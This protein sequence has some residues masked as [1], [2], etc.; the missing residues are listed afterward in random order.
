MY[1]LLHVLFF[2]VSSSTQKQM[3]SKVRVNELE[4]YIR[5]ECLEISGIPVDQH[6]DTNSIVIK[7]GSLMGVI[8]EKSDISVSHRLPSKSQSY[9]N[10]VRQGRSSL[11]KIIAKFVRRD[12]RDQFYSGRKRLKNKTTSDLGMTGFAGSNRIYISESLSP[13]NKRLFQECLK[14][15]RE[16]NFKFIWTHYGRIY[17]RKDSNS[18]TKVVCNQKDLEKIRKSTGS[19]SSPESNYMRGDG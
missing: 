10:A 17:L 12:I 2:L 5:R 18:S 7:V 16:E 8:V 19:V 14:L 13:K 11:A 3:G 9:S 1:F 4:Q 6:E 15:K